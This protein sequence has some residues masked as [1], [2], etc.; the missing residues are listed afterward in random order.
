MSKT[1]VLE[2]ERAFLEQIVQ[3]MEERGIPCIPTQSAKEAIKLAQNPE[4]DTAIIDQILEQEDG[5][6]QKYQGEAVVRNIHEIRPDLAS[7]FF[8]K[9][10]RKDLK[11][12]PGVIEVISKPELRQDTE[13]TFDRLTSLIKM[14][15]E[16]SLVAI[17]NLKDHE[18]EQPLKIGTEY[19]LQAGV[20]HKLTGND[21]LNPDTKSLEI[22][23][24]APGMIIMPDW[25][26][27]INLPQQENPT[28]I[29]FQLKP[30]QVGDTTIRVKFH[31]QLDWRGT[32]EF[33]VKVIEDIVC[34]A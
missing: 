2:D 8:T 20:F 1:L 21:A 13:A 16:G 25:S 7:I 28:L 4:I 9:S 27:E 19:E 33:K 15:S 6:L 12:L 5:D 17:A 34:K 18:Q 23:V 26:Q 29:S 14:V 31:H 10:G 11:E 30:E 32:L 22:T 3:N 24:Q